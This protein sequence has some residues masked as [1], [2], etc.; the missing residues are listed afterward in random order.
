VDALCVE[1]TEPVFQNWERMW[2][3]AVA[4]G[5]DTED[6][7]GER[8]SS[9][10]WLPYPPLFKRVVVKVVS[11]RPVEAPDSHFYRRV[12]SAGRGNE[13]RPGVSY[14]RCRPEC[15]A[16]IPMVSNPIVPP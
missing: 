9:P 10:S 4:E 6:E 16:S 5:W 2:R 13:P 8:W 12:L 14:S 7:R 15:D 3:N 11:K 1:F